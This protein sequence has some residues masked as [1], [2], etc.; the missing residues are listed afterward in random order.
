MMLIIIIEL[1]WNSIKLWWVFNVIHQVT[2]VWSVWTVQKIPPK[3]KAFSKATNNR[4]ADTA[5]ADLQV[6]ISWI[7][8]ETLDCWRSNLP[9]FCLWFNYY[10]TLRR[11]LFL[12]KIILS[13]VLENGLSGLLKWKAVQQR[14]K[15]N[16]GSKEIL[17]NIAKINLISEQSR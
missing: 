9:Q 3:I 5:F 12:I 10:W 7:V 2:Y 16:V 4:K 15:Y 11:Y 13:H 14:R 8:L 6:G 1:W 17:E